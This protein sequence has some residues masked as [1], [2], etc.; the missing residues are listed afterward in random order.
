MAECERT[1]LATAWIQE[2]SETAGRALQGRGHDALDIV[3][4]IELQD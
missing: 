4:N 1:T 2:Q 3:I